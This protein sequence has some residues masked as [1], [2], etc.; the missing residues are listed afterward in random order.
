MTRTEK[1]NAVCL[2]I[3]LMMAVEKVMYTGTTENRTKME[4]AV[5]GLREIARELRYGKEAMS[6]V[7]GTE[8]ELHG[9]P[10]EKP[11]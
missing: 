10:G 8:N 1:Y 5:E 11:C 3:D 2:A 7:N 6:V 4:K 9:Q